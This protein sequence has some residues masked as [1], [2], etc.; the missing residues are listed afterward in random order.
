MLDDRSSRI[1]PEDWGSILQS[2]RDRE[3]LSIQMRREAPPIEVTGTSEPVSHLASEAVSQRSPRPRPDMQLPTRAFLTWKMQDEFGNEV[4]APEAERIARFLRAIHLK[5]PVK[6]PESLRMTPFE[7]R[8]RPQDVTERRARQAEEIE[9]AEKT[10]EEV[11]NQSMVQS[12][13]L[14]NEIQF[15]EED[16]DI[17]V[18]LRRCR[19]LLQMFLPE[20]NVDGNPGRERSSATVRVYWGAIW[21]FLQLARSANFRQGVPNDDHDM[22]P[23]LTNMV[24]ELLEEALD[25]HEGVKCLRPK[26]DPETPSQPRDNDMADGV[27]LLAAIVDSLGSIFHMFIEAA[28]SSNSQARARSIDSSSSDVNHYKEE[29]RS[30]LR[31]ARSQLIVEAE[32]NDKENTIGPV[33]TPEAISIAIMNRLVSGVYRSGPVDVVD[34]YEECLEYLVS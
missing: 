21:E 31:K 8:K 22:V 27:V 10:F 4:Q 14:G 32:G 16:E 6:L 28:R 20:D 24:N 12:P 2:H 18:L 13:S 9:F 7:Q 26:I 30:S 34:M 3:M 11:R 29:A 33:L 15:F 19:Q 1:E 5:L 17:V 23:C 25:I